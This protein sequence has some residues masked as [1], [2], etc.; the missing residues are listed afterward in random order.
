MSIICNPPAQ[1][2]LKQMEAKTVPNVVEKAQDT[3]K[4]P[5]GGLSG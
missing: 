4:F 1:I 3:E 2:F 5:Q